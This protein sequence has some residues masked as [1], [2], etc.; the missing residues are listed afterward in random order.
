MDKNL[1]LK[2][3]TLKKMKWKYRC[4]NL[5]K[6]TALMW[7]QTKHIIGFL[8]PSR[9]PTV[10]CRKGSLLV[11]SYFINKAIKQYNASL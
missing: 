2:I 8:Q 6:C 9:Q 1:G 4:V 11:E 10:G 3:E 7:V 5:W